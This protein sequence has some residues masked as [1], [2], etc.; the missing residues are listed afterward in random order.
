MARLDLSSANRRQQDGVDLDQVVILRFRSQDAA[1][2]RAR[3][4]RAEVK[5][6]NDLIAVRDAQI[7]EMDHRIKNHL[8]LL[9]SVAR[10]DGRDPGRSGR[11]VAET[12][13]RRVSA[14]ATVHDA[15]HAK[16]EHGPIPA[17]ALLASLCA[18]FEGQRHSITVSCD[19]EVDIAAAQLGP[20]GM[21]ITE[22]VSNSLKHA[23]A[24]RDGS[25]SIELTRVGENLS[26]EISDDGVG[27]PPA[28]SEGRVSGL[29]LLAILSQ[30][31]GGRHSLGVSRSGGALLSVTFPGRAPATRAA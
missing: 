2:A 14:I 21:I 11:E 28:R 1:K 3:S 27:F 15:F 22:A 18:P 26:L 7:R 9:A 13:A 29:R 17:K 20:L 19:P 6:L 24:D 16:G 8:Q 30:Q 25:I 12:V 23:F 5:R 4:V 10:Q 31:L